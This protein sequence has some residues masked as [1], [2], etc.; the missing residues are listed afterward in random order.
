[1][2]SRASMSPTAGEVDASFLA[3]AVLGCARRLLLILPCVLVVSQVFFPS[4]LVIGG[5]HLACDT[6]GGII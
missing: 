4:V 5:E 2:L 6:T 3:L 1:M